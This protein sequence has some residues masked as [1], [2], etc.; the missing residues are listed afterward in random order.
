MN[1]GA[2]D[3]NNEGGMYVIKQLG[4]VVESWNFK[5]DPTAWMLFECVKCV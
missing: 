5:G 1:M 4:K 2:C 3:W